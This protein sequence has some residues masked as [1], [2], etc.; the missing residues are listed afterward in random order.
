V[1]MVCKVHGTDCT[2]CTDKADKS[3]SSRHIP[4]A[5]HLESLE[6]LKSGRHDGACL[7]LLSVVSAPPF[8]A[9]KRHGD[10][11]IETIKLVLVMIRRGQATR[12]SGSLRYSTHRNGSSLRPFFL[13]IARDGL[14]AEDGRMRMSYA[15]VTEGK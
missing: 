12:E 2:D 5:V 3:Q 9:D 14:R 8:H 11:G 13:E 10:A 4:C 15:K 7:L 1:W 6:I